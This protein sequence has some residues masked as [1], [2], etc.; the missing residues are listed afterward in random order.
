[1]CRAGGRLNTLG[2]D[3]TLFCILAIDEPGGKRNLVENINAQLKVLKR[4]IITETLI[5]TEIIF[6]DVSSLVWRHL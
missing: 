2:K 1:M 6:T 4:P 5:K 3:D